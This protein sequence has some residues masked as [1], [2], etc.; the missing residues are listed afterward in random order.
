M[1][2]ETLKKIAEYVGY[3]TKTLKGSAKL[4]CLKNPNAQI[5]SYFEY[6]PLT[7]NDQMVEIMEKLLQE[8]GMFDFEKLKSGGVAIRD[9][10]DDSKSLGGG[11]TVNE[12]VLNAASEL[13]KDK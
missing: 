11:K 3:E 10:W 7:N 5:P 4:Y 1:E 13:V 12:A 2:T 8:H 9:H 6:I